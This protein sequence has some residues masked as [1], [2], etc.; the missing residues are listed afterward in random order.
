LDKVCKC[1]A[2][3]SKREKYLKRNLPSRFGFTPLYVSPDSQLKY[4]K[5]GEEAFDS[6]L[7]KIVDDYIRVDSVV[8]DIGA[9]VGVFT[10]AA[11]SR[12]L[13]GSVLAVEADIWMAQLLRK[14]VTVQGV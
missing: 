1:C 11:A 6:G 2:Q 7:L 8:W 5:L 10:F 14:F 12:T 13:Q 9:N 4:I 3:S